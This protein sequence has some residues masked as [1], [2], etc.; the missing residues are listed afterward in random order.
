[1]GGGIVRLLTIRMSALVAVLTLTGLGS[2]GS[3]RKSVVVAV[4]ETSTGPV[5]ETTSSTPPVPT[6]G[7]SVVPASHTLVAIEAAAMLERINASENFSRVASAGEALLVPTLLPAWAADMVPA[8]VALSED[9]QDPEHPAYLHLAWR[10][11]DPATGGTI[12][13]VSLRRWR[14]SEGEVGADR[15][16]TVGG[17]RVYTTLPG[18]LEG[19]CAKDEYVS[20]SS[21]EPPTLD[22]FE[23]G[24]RYSL[25]M[26]PLP[27]CGAAPYTLNDVIRIADALVWCQPVTSG[28]SC[29]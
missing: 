17:T 23:S 26:V 5:E 7:A 9:A 8:V 4:G 3:E 20:E 6:D 16:P 25:E 10:R 15:S 1:M 22:W 12:A 11:T 29:A 24:F 27:Y 18:A 13:S 14:A 19:R 2:C 21:D 28:Y